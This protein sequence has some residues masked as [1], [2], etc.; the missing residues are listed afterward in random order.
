MTT[1]PTHF[2]NANYELVPYDGSPVSWRVSIY[3]LVIENN[4]L[5][6]IKNADEKYYDIPGGGVK[7]GETLEQALAREG[8][9]EAGWELTP[10]KPIW[11]M[12]DWFYHSV[13]KA[14]YRSLQQFWTAKG[15][16]VAEPTDG[17]I[18]EVMQAP[19][20]QFQN[21]DLYPNLVEVLSKMKELSPWLKPR[22]LFYLL[23]PLA[24]T[25]VFLARF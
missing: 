14:F 18:T 23:T 16:K 12:S 19:F 7:L 2:R 13:E 1:L 22:L 4:S 11:T 5:L 17:R 15:Q 8:L 9:E 21:Y 10:V 20:D 3:G 25:K 24:K 6:I